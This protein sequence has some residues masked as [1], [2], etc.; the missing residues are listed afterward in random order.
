MIKAQDL[1]F[2]KRFGFH[3]PP[4]A[5]LEGY[6][7]VHKDGISGKLTCKDCGN[8][9]NIFLRGDPS[10]MTEEQQRGTILRKASEK[11][12]CE[13]VQQELAAKSHRFFCDI[14]RGLDKIRSAEFLKQT[15]KA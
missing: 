3:R 5:H 11:H 8:E 9:V 14:K 1:G 15:G 6:M 2:L 13:A 4:T 7:C 10:K 12:Q